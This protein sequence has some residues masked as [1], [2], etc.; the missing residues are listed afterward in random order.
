MTDIL[1]QARSHQEY[2]VRIRRQLHANP[3]LSLHEKQ[4]SEL[5]ASELGTLNIPFQKAGEHGLVAT[6]SGAAPGRAIALRADMDALP[7]EEANSHI[8]YAS[9]NP[10]VMHACGHDG[11]VAM[12]LGAAHILSRNRERLHG[13]VKL[14]FQ[15][16]E[17]IG[18]GT[19]AIRENLSASNVQS[20]FGIHLWSEFESGKISL[21]PGT[22]MASA[23]AMT[24]TVKGR[25][26][27]AAYAHCGIDPIMAASAIVLNCS[28]ITSREIDPATPSSISFGKISG[29]ERP[30]IIP[31][32]VTLLGTIRTT[33]PTSQRGL[34]DAVERMARMTAEAHRAS[35][36]ISWSKGVGMVVNDELCSAIAIK[37]A[38]HL[39]LAGRISDFPSLMA[40]ENFADYLDDFPGVFAIIGVRNSDL[41]TDYPHH[42]PRFNL[43]ESTFYLGAALHAQYAFES[44]AS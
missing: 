41:Q 32:E 15:Q 39:G 1:E 14:C 9:R 37:A 16:A 35:V 29:G 36:D 31:E 20:I 43:D 12:L 8:D 6:I 25:G 21:Q 10:G 34:M 40:S 28:A 33:D 42:H 38:D 22:R 3:E 7:I 27:H 11:H 26:T 24:I 2:M 23:K 18:Q 30:N 17:E 13:S 5:I 4:T 44:L 19:K